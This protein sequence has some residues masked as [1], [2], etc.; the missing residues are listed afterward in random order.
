VKSLEGK[1]NVPTRQRAVKSPPKKVTIGDVAK[2]AGVSIGTVSNVMNG[3]DSVTE[4]RRN[5]VNEAIKA[6]SFTGSLLAKGMRTQRYP[7]VGLCVPNTTSS[8]FVFMS[9][10]LEEHAARESYELVQ[11]ITRHDPDREVARIRRLIASKASG[12]LLLPSLE[13]KGVLEEL[14]SA[15]MPT[16]V[17]NRFVAEEDRFDQVTVDHKTAFAKAT[18]QMIEWGHRR[19]I[20]ASQ[21]PNFSVVQQNVAGIV[22]A[23]EESSEEVS[24]TVLKCG[25]DQK[26]YEKMLGKE[27]GRSDARTVLVASSSLLSAWSIEAFR[28]LGIKCPEDIS[29][30][31]AEE[32]DWAMAASPTLSSIQQPTRDLSRIAWDLLMRRMSGGIDAPVT[33]RCDARINFRESV[34]RS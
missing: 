30:L 5:R 25:A 23:I 9:D 8:N 13:P 7:V 19:I 1:N 3:R 18:R 27:I 4:Q 16:V 11:M 31:A 32:P 33:I 28:G 26:L 34:S 15:N 29:L 10:M 14:R 17:I 24:H 21:F 6:L 12:V 22:Q 2:L 20:I